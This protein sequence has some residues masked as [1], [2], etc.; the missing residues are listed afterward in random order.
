MVAVTDHPDLQGL[1][2]SASARVNGQLLLLPQNP[3]VKKW[4]G[5]PVPFSSRL[6]E[7]KGHA[8][9]TRV[10]SLW[11]MLPVYKAGCGARWN[12]R[13]LVCIVWGRREGM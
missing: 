10:H 2:D 3:G 8:C 13:T 11:E 6:F 9:Q 7:V 5:I 12:P 4:F 1:A